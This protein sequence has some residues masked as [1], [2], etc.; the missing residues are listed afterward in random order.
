[1]KPILLA[2]ILSLA[3]ATAGTAAER[4]VR[5][6]ELRS[7]VQAGTLLC[8]AWDAAAGRC[9]AIYRWDAAEGSLRETRLE[10]LGGQPIVDTAL[11]YD[12]RVQ[13]DQLCTTLDADGMGYLFIVGGRELE[14]AEAA[15]LREAVRS[16]YAAADGRVWC[17]AY[18]RDTVSGAL[19]AEVRVDGAP[20]LELDTTFQPIETSPLPQLRM[21]RQPWSV[22]V[23]RAAALIPQPP[24][25]P[26]ATR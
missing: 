24:A 25:A 19:R 14:A 7:M 8:E 13:G 26:T 6:P 20:R 16:V 15:P 21:A 22:A 23:L 9:Q 5:G 3:A 11:Q 2:L 4:R 18:Y 12:L 10:T 17:T 1:M